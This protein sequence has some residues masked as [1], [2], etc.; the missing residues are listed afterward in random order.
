ME[1]KYSCRGKS[2]VGVFFCAKLNKW[3][4]CLGISRDSCG[5]TCGQCGKLMLTKE[6]AQSIFY[7]LCQPSFLSAA[8]CQSLS[9]KKKLRVSPKGDT[10]SFAVRRKTRNDFHSYPGT[11]NAAKIT[12]ISFISCGLSQKNCGAAARPGSLPR[13]NPRCPRY[14]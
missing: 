3:A 1:T 14:R 10:R 5:E 8:F 4:Y 13:K 11:D 12:T 9:E 6:N 2:S 7:E